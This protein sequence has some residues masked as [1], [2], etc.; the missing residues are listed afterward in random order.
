MGALLDGDDDTII[1]F[2]TTNQYVVVIALNCS[3]AFDS[4]RHSTL[5]QQNDRFGHSR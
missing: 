1:Q 4:V 2:L 5:T 3:K